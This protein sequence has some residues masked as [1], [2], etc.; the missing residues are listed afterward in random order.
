ME[1]DSSVENGKS[2][3]EGYLTSWRKNFYKKNINFLGNNFLDNFLDNPVFK[4]IF[5]AI[6]FGVIA[7][8]IGGFTYGLGTVNLVSSY[9]LGV[10]GGS[11][12]TFFAN[13]FLEFF[14]KAENFNSIQSE[15]AYKK[16]F[17]ATLVI[18]CVSVV[19]AVLIATPI[20]G[21]GFIPLGTFVAATLASAFESIAI[22]NALSAY[23]FG[24][25]FKSKHDENKRKDLSGDSLIKGE[26]EKPGVIR[27]EKQV[28][29]EAQGQG[30]K[31]NNL[32]GQQQG[33]DDPNFSDTQ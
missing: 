20:F 23:D 24:K 14:S 27:K 21:I 16:R 31:P 1:N 6:L 13:S 32:E 25:K 29:K 4:N 33:N 2:K 22:L 5:F 30:E 12:L 10:F 11:A 28:A 9:F 17:I 26:E 18:S 3:N 8:L 15:K 19:A 7:V